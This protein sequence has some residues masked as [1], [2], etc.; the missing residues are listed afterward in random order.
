MA[1]REAT[2][3]STEKR[4]SAR[5]RPSLSRYPAAIAGFVL[6]AI[7]LLFWG[8]GF[9]VY[10]MVNRSK[11][12]D[13]G[14]RLEAVG[15]VAAAELRR[16]F[17][18]SLSELAQL[19]LTF[20]PPEDFGG[21]YE[22]RQLEFLEGENELWLQLRKFAEGLAQRASLHSVMI[23][24]IH[25]RAIADSAGAAIPFEPFAYLDLDRYEMEMAAQDGRTWTTPYY[26]MR[27]A[28]EMAGVLSTAA[29]LD[30]RDYKRSYTPIMDAGGEP[31]AFLRLEASRAYFEEMREMRGRLL[32]LA[33]VMTTL[34][35]IVALIVR[36]LL[37]NLLN[38]EEAISHADRL[39]SVATLAA[40]FAH[41]VR[42]PLG[43]IR[44]CA[45]GLV[46][47]LGEEQQDAAALAADM[48]EEVVRLDG[49]ITQFLDFA[50]PA[51]T[52]SWGAVDI[53]ETIRAVLALARKGLE[54]KKLAVETRLDDSAPPIWANPKSIRQVL[55]NL[56]LNA[57][58]AT[59][60]GGRIEIETRARKNQLV[61]SIADTGKGIPPE[62]LH[63]VFDP[64]FTTK[65]GG[66]GLG[67]SLS[68]RIIEQFGGTIDIRSQAGRGAT[69][70]IRF[71]I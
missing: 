36:R 59:D 56:L 68:R 53:A 52:G 11:E 49:L 46:E 58:E 25:G 45:E 50:R 15:E 61:V 44:S 12:R 1:K 14:L 63:R 65:Q 17:D 5:R 28:P 54:E 8:G 34:L 20:W 9:Y 21:I 35:F 31:F 18:W 13:L 4:R 3:K 67:L 55:L 10:I 32:A 41:E 26:T 57:Q 51:D 71:P 27:G 69:V 43:I 47:E 24:D 33:A 29:P 40:G 66:T 22:E 23:V 62:V 39:Q 60:S 6:T 38:A 64:F 16:E 70:E 2:S 42:N 7:L 48:V 30:T 37:A 19:T